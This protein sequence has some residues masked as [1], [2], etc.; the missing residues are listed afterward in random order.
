MRWQQHYTALFEEIKAY[1][2]WPAKKISDYRQHPLAND[3]A[4]SD[5][6]LRIFEFQ[7]RYNRFYRHY[8]K[9]HSATEPSSWREIP[10]LWTT[11]F[12]RARIACFPKSH[13]CAYFLTSGTTESQAGVHEFRD[14]DLYECG[15]MA[16]FCLATL[17]D[18]PKIKMFFLTPAPRE[19][20]HSSLV[21]MLECARQS[22]G[23]T[24]SRYF[25]SNDQLDTHQFLK[26]LRRASEESEPVFV[27]GTSFAFVYL[28]DALRCH[29]I[30]FALPK[31][32][33]IL[34]TGG[35]K[36]R[37]REVPK[38]KL[39][40]EL[41]AWLGISRPYIVNE[42]GMTELSSQFYDA[43]LSLTVSG[44]AFPQNWLSMKIAP[45]WT[46]VVIVDPCSGEEVLPGHRGL[47]RIYDLANLGS[48]VSI[49]TEDVGVKCREGFE[50]LG[51]IASA[52]AR[53]CSLDAENLLVGDLTHAAVPIRQ[54]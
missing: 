33:R 25:L 42:Y 35:F 20:P 26:A 21:F 50:V 44:H 30:R 46:R 36:G 12:K 37:V 19:V 24:G 4:F 32:S 3:A 27:L 8:V 18:L 7:F 38:D 28:L 1:L 51:R 10:P 9:L 5:L 17:P 47:I 13:R 15:A 6:A 43:G 53:G 14:L 16:L 2:C 22:F 45:P 40:H 23:T 41:E 48:V 39:Y 52:P 34:E 54:N 49:Q 11:A 31:G 29:G